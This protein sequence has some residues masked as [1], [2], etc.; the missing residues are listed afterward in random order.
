VVD[1][2]GEPH[3]KGLIARLERHSSHPIAK[4]LVS[5]FGDQPFD[6]DCDIAEVVETTGGGISA[7]LGSQFVY[8]GSFSYLRTHGVEI[9]G[10]TCDNALAT[11]Y[12][13]LGLAIDGR[14]VAKLAL[15]DAVRDDTQAAIAAIGQFGWHA[16]IISGDSQAVVEQVA[17]QVGIAP[18]R[19]RGEVTPEQKLAMVRSQANLAT[20][21]VGD[22]VNDAAALAAADVG[23]AV[24]GG[25]AASLAAADVYIAQPGLAPVVMLVRLSRR[26][27]FV[28]RRNLVISLSY[29]ALAVSLAAAGLITP[30]V[31]AVLMPISS[32]TVLLSAV[33]GLSDKE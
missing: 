23:I 19:A 6:A 24:H 17:R 11:P 16:S 13:W 18:S 29:N 1:Y 25:A 22:G 14:V 4:S 27:L 31:A 21:M 10:Q 33:N 2:Q 8:F 12:T 3:Y 28:A 26:A 32:V 9:N 5:Q 20:T 7:R 15:G 30:L